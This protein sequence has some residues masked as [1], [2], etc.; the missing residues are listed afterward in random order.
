MTLDTSASAATPDILVEA[1]LSGVEATT[2]DLF[3]EGAAGSYNA[4]PRLIEREGRT[5]RFSL[6]STG[7]KVEE[8]GTLHLH[9]VLVEG[10]RAVTLETSLAGTGGAPR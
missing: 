4:V 9:L 1:E 8:D 10:A 2:V 5:A 3:A 6:P 7:F